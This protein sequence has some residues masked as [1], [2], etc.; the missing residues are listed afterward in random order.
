LAR[1]YLLSLLDH[2]AKRSPR[3]FRAAGRAES[4]LLEGLFSLSRRLSPDRASALGARVGGFLGPRLR[5]YQDIVSNLAIAF[6]DWP[7]E[8]L[9]ATALAVC[10][11]AGRTVMEFPHLEALSSPAAADRVEVVYLSRLGPSQY[12]RKPGIFVTAHLGNWYLATVASSRLELPLSV[13]YSPQQNPFLERL[14]ARYRH[15]IGAEAIP[16][17]SAGRGIM[18]ALK[19]GRSVGLVMDQRFEGGELVPFFGVGAPTA[20]APARIAVKLGIDFVPVRVER[21]K[22]ARFRVTVYE[23]IGRDPAIT[24]PRVAALAMTRQVNELFESW[25]RDAPEQ[26]LCAKR[27]WPRN[28][29]PDSGPSP[30]GAER[31]RPARRNASTNS[32]G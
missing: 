29:L 30:A 9:Q 11:Q 15:S 24:D 4:L 27:R 20:V 5:K 7:G 1:L 32:V 21:L 31:Q 6:P 19:R 13:V 28:V 8:R 10:R 26:W 14:L 16:S 18:E 2:A 25:I 3:L 22:G 23:S 12:G 17:S